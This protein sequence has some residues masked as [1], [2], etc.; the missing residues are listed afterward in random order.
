M[1]NSVFGRLVSVTGGCDPVRHWQR[2]LALYYPEI[3]EDPK[4]LR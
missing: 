3:L 2:M 4:T 1:N